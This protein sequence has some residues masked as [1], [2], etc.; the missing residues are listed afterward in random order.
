[1]ARDSRS[2]RAPNPKKP[3]DSGGAAGDPVVSSPVG[4]HRALWFGL[5]MFIVLYDE[6]SDMRSDDP[7]MAWL[8]AHS[9]GGVGWPGSACAGDARHLPGPYGVGAGVYGMVSWPHHLR[10]RCT[11]GRW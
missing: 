6:R 2:A 1:V 9:C 3:R 11:T 4:V 5:V 10:S 7:L 8:S